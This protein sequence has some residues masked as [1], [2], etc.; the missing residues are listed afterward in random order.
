MAVSPW[1]LLAGTVVVFAVGSSLASVR[2]TAGAAADVLEVSIAPELIRGQP[3]ADADVWELQSGET[4]SGLYLTTLFGRRYRLTA[5]GYRPY[6]FELVPWTGATLEVPDCLE[7]KPTVVV[8]IPPGPATMAL[9]A[10]RF[11]LSVLEP[12]APPQEILSE[13]RLT[14]NHRAVLLGE[15]SPI[16][17]SALSVWS[18]ELM[19]TGLTPAIQAQQLLGW[20]DPQAAD[21]RRDLVPGTRLRAEL[22]S[23]DTANPRVLARCEFTITNEAFQDVGLTP[24]K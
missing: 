22:L 10:A 3:A 24:A 18:L 6:S 11:R 7:R 1:F 20:R 13:L 15:A 5:P 2:I 4:R 19:A 8:R 17:A 23:A 21:L 16:P 14:G 9:D 12:N